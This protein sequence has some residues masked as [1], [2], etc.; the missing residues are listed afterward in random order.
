MV[1]VGP[2]MLKEM[3]Q[4][5]IDIMQNSKVAQDMHK[6]YANKHKTHIE[7]E[8]GHHVD[9][10]VRPNRSSLR[11]GSCAKLAPQICGPFHILE[12]IGPMVY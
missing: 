4:E 6:V 1:H 8:V 7:F 9:L 12:R 11:S 2:Q 10:W 3:E 5:L